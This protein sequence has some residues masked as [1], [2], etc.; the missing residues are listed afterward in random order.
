MRALALWTSPCVASLAVAGR[1]GAQ[2]PEQRKVSLPVG[3]KSLLYY[4][5]LTI[6]EM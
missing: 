6:A 3:G 1:A 4:L 5:P 2:A